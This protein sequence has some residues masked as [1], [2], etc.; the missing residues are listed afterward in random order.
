M[1]SDTH[2]RIYGYDHL[3]GQTVLKE[4][5]CSYVEKYVVI[6]RKK[7]VLILSSLVGWDEQESNRYGLVSKHTLCLNISNC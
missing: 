4:K 3:L 6:C 7:Y 1:Q 2:T 5:I